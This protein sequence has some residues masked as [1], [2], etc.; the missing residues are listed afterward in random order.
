[1]ERGGGGER[2]RLKEDDRGVVFSAGSR[3]ASNNDDTLCDWT[4]NRDG[5]YKLKR[6]GRRGKGM[7]EKEG[8]R[9]EEG[10]VK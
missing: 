4:D 8:R 1:M 7:G 9:G 6:E 2:E 10:V 3:E 5:K